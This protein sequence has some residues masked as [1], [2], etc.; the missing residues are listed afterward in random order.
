MFS[1]FIVSS[2]TETEHTHH[3]VDEILD[4]I[5]K[6]YNDNIPNDFSK[7]VAATK[8]KVS[9]DL[10]EDYTRVLTRYHQLQLGSYTFGVLCRGMCRLLGKYI[11]IGSAYCGSGVY[12][13]W[14]YYLERQY[15]GKRIDD[16]PLYAHHYKTFTELLAEFLKHLMTKRYEVENGKI[17]VHAH[18]LPL[19]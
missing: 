5:V 8:Y 1:C 15:Y 19:A 12:A 4:G 3:G 16:S 6:Y 18:S 11:T 9:P 14:N 10:P 17:V 7:F 13:T 2:N